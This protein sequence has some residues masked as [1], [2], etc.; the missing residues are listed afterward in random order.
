MSDLIQ[1]LDIRVVPDSQKIKLKEDL[2]I[3]ES[4][5][6]SF[7]LFLAVNFGF[8]NWLADGQT[9]LDRDRRVVYMNPRT[10]EAVKRECKIKVV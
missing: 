2:L 3:S 10:A 1:G 9:V 4:V 7:N 5:R 8:S 6:N